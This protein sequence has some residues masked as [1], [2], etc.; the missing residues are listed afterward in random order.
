[1]TGRHV[2]CIFLPFSIHRVSGGS[3]LDH[4]ISQTDQK[5]A[6]HFTHVREKNTNELDTQEINKQN[7]VVQ[8][9]HVSG[10]EEYC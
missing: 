7:Q 8:C 5:A 4:I 10:F 2:K 1:M 9:V 3:F 6:V